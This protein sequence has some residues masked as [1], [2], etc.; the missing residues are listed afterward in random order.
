MGE[1]FELWTP[2]KWLP[3]QVSLNDIDANEERFS[4]L[5]LTTL[6]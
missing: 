2:E 6:L 3:Q 5:D 1:Y 4:A